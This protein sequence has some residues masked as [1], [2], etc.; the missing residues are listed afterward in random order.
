[1]RAA[2]DAATKAGVT[3]DPNIQHMLKQWL[4]EMPLQNQS[5]GTPDAKASSEQS[6]AQSKSPSGPPFIS[7]PV[8]NAAQSK[9]S[10]VA[11]SVGLQVP[12]FPPFPP[13]S[14]GNMPAAPFRGMSAMGTSPIQPHIAAPPV[15]ASLTTQVAAQA[16]TSLPASVPSSTTP[17]VQ[18]PPPAQMAV[19]KT[20]APEPVMTPA[21]PVIPPAA[22]GAGVSIFKKP[23]L[24]GKEE[25]LDK[26]MDDF[27]SEI[28]TD[29]LM[30]PPA[31]TAP[32]VEEPAAPPQ[33]QAEDFKKKSLKQLLKLAK[34]RGIDV[35][36]C[37]EKSDVIEQLRSAP[38]QVVEE[39]P[40]PAPPVEE[41][42]QEPHPAEEN[43]IADDGSF[44]AKFLAMQTNSSPPVEKPPAPSE[45][46][47]PAPQGDGG[48]DSLKRLKRSREEVVRK[49]QEER[50]AAR[51]RE[52]SPPPPPREKSPPPPLPPSEALPPAPAPAEK[53]YKAWPGKE[54]DEV[55]VEKK[56]PEAWEFMKTE[57]SLWGQGNFFS[58]D[59]FDK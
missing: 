59:S 30:E 54:D 16:A 7:E 49:I 17:A 3:L 33:P 29:V 53:L 11:P 58:F 2:V 18:E 45:G 13:M 23:V 9:A 27:F 37:V 6:A 19:E 44:M 57:N 39:A 40:A 48:E 35:S 32:V 47:A 14:P 43:Q 52:A 38:P 46:D 34:E 50:K 31:E 28:G 56:A 5:V 36:G 42:Q 51:R 55:K 8:P 15:D 25:D 21:K 41:K 20:K 12:T 10:G 4:G 26:A 1:M 24:K 22:P